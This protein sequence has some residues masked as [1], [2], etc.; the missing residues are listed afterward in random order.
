MTDKNRNQGG[1][2]FDQDWD[3][4]KN[5]FDRQRNNP[6]D[7]NQQG[8]GDQ[9]K[10]GYGGSEFGNTY[11]RAGNENQANNQQRNYIP[12]NDD[13]RDFGNQYGRGNQF[14]A[15][16]DD[17][18]QQG[19]Q[20]NQSS[21]G[22]DRMNYA[23]NQYGHDYNPGGYARVGNTDSNFN[24][25][26]N[27][28]RS[29]SYDR[30]RPG[31]GH[32]YGHNPGNNNRGDRDWWDRTKDKV[33]SWFDDNDHN[34]SRGNINRPGE[35]R[36]KGPKGYQRSADRIR[37]DICD[38][39]SDDPYVDA[40]EI[41]VRIEGSEVILS[42]TVHSKEA[43][44]RAEDIVESISGVR[45][46]ENHIRVD[47]SSADSSNRSFA[48]RDYTGTSDDIGSIGKESGTTNEIIRNTGNM[49]PNR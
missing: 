30:G 20:Q 1:Q 34:E 48:N 46:V 15:Q 45:T 39:L 41:D 26:N 43:K 4:N 44:R 5:R 6:Q 32:G 29:E 38:R 27:Y 33:T 25:M 16:Q 14:R 37:E 23:S 49:R 18:R 9:L 17:W 22:R 42:G 28:D 40:S 11:Y 2:S 8:Y 7:W 19:N 13:N 47:R 36:G 21:F 35:H 3:Q 24:D 12:D 31:Y 10:G